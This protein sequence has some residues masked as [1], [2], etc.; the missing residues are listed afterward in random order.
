MQM[1][2]FGGLPLNC[3]DEDVAVPFSVRQ[4]YFALAN[5]SLDEDGQLAV[6]QP[7]SITR[8]CKLYCG[9]NSI[10]IQEQLD[11]LM[12]VAARGR[13]VLVARWRDGSKRQTFAKVTNISRPRRTDDSNYQEV[14]VTWFIDY[15][16]WM[17]T[18]DE[19]PYFDHQQLFDTDQYMDGN[20]TAITVNGLSETFTIANEGTVAINRGQLVIIPASGAS[21]ENLVL[22]N[23]TNLMEWRYNGIIGDP[24]WLYVDFLSRTCKISAVNSYDEVETPAGQME[25][26]TLELGDN[27]IEL[28]V[29]A[30]TG[31]TGFEWH[32][33]RQYV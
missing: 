5:G 26:M 4:N 30:V 13:L 22:T 8:A 28:T 2:L 27:E 11:A 3:V 18:E 23:T 24:H 20:Y 21:I 17:A 33:A 15:P 29:E 16:Y 10:S 7:Y 1:I 9:P 14:S 31:N 19:P 32:W 25:W 6:L 12:T